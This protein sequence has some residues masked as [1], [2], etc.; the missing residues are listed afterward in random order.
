MAVFAV[1][2]VYSPDAERLDA[3]RPEHRAFLRALHDAG[4]VVVSG[5]LVP[6]DGAPAGALIVVD[7][8]DAAAAAALLD[9]DPFRHAGL[10]TERTVREWVP[11]IGSLAR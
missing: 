10:V 6:D 11:V 2:Y 4:R 5:P 1:T 8:D 9:A 3:L 7:A